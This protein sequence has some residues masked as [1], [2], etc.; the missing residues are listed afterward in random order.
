MSSSVLMS[1]RII[2]IPLVCRRRLISAR[3]SEDSGRFSIDGNQIQL[4]RNDGNNTLHGGTIGFSRKA[5]TIEKITD[6]PAPSVTFSLVSPDGDENFP[7]ELNVSVTFTLSEENDLIIEYSAQTSKRTVINL[8]NH[9]Y[10]NLDGHAGDVV[11]QQLFISADHILE[12][13]ADM[14]PTGKLLPVSGHALDFRKMKEC[15]DATDTTFVLNG[16]NDPSAQLFSQKTGIR[17]SVFTDRPAIHVYVGGNCFGKIKGKSNASYHTHSGICFE[18]Q[19]YPD[20][21]N[22]PDFPNPYLNPGETYRQKTTYH[23]DFE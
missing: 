9:S 19:N 4:N 5:W 12:K 17:M 20:A 21:P 16:N 22:H 13:R 23:F 15:P 18:A 11:S 6:S 1:F 8:T 2:S 3:P 14:I 7:G 10:F